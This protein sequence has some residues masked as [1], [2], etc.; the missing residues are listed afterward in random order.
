MVDVDGLLWVEA[1]NQ[2]VR[3]HLTGGQRL[4]RE[5]MSGIEAALGRTRFTRVHRRAI[6]SMRHVRVL[7][8]LPR[9]R[10]RLLLQNGEWI[11]VSRSRLQR[12]RES[13]RQITRAG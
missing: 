1:A 2:Y 7:E 3:L 12:V 8:L 13:L 11:H 9:G 6:V 5:S 10:A 4:M